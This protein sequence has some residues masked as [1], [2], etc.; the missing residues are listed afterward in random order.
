MQYLVKA[1][2]NN[3]NFLLNVGPMPNGKIQPEFQDTLKV[4]GQWLSK[5]GETIYGTRGGPVAA[6]SW[7]V[8]TQKGK[9]VFLHVLQAEDAHL[10][11][12]GY[13]AKV[14]SV[15]VFGTTTKL[16]FKQDAFGTVI[17]LPAKLDD[18]DTVLVME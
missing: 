14:N 17:Q 15:T 10:L 6:K 7:G 2:G 16:P 8:S 1:A 18:I 11:L 12:S 13:T 4:V 9:R 3:A 5:Y